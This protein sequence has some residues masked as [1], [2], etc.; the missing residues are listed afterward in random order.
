MSRATALLGVPTGVD[1]LA[2]ACGL[3]M[4]RWKRRHLSSCRTNRPRLSDFD[5]LTGSEI[6]EFPQSLR[7]VPSVNHLLLAEL[8]ANASHIPH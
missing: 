7:T 6:P 3:V 5:P 4:R 8:A 1:C 2:I